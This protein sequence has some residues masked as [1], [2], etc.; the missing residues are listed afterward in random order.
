MRLRSIYEYNNRLTRVLTA[1]V[2]KLCNCQGGGKDTN[3]SQYYFIPRS[4]LAH[5]VNVYR[6]HH[7]RVKDMVRC[8][9]EGLGLVW[10]FDD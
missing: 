2:C 6:F 3:G 9:L 5:L 7:K 8:R 10:Y 1:D 4:M